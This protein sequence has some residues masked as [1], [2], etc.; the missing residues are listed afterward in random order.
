MKR[1][2]FIGFSVHITQVTFHINKKLKIHQLL[3]NEEGV[4]GQEQTV[5][6][7]EL[8]SSPKHLNS[9]WERENGKK[10]EKKSLIQRCFP[11]ERGEEINKNKRRRM[12]EWKNARTRKS[13]TTTTR[14]EEICMAF[15]WATLPPATD[16]YQKRWRRRLLPLADAPERQGACKRTRMTDQW[17]PRPRWVISFL[18]V[19]VRFSLLFLSSSV[20]SVYPSAARWCWRWCGGGGTSIINAFRSAIIIAAANTHSGPWLCAFPRQRRVGAEEE[21]ETTEKYDKYSKEK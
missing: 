8:N 4:K 6:Y 11:W 7:I 21:E 14:L 18:C 3:W 12:R 9:K 1:P 10:R 15:S 13:R 20:V 16:G 17:A 5:G 2:Y 19:C